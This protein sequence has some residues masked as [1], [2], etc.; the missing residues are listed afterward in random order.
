MQP[1]PHSLFDGLLT[2]ANDAGRDR[3]RISDMMSASE[4]RAVMTLILLFAL[5]N[6]VPMPPGTSGILGAP[7]LFFAVQAALGQKPWLPASI[8]GRSMSRARFGAWVGRAQAWLARADGLLQPRFQWLV[9][10]ATTR[11][12]GTLCSLLA[13]ILFLPIPFG[14]MAPALAISLLALGVLER[15]GLWLLAGIATALIA[16]A[17][18]CGVSTVIASLASG[19]FLRA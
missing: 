17:V 11:L 19:L 14:N 2:L 16:I 18:A 13:L 1:A 5:P 9:R 3:I 15:D 12:V 8:A 4:D 10:P 7:L 6:I